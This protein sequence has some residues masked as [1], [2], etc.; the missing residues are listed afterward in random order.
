MTGNEHRPVLVLS[1]SQV[2]ELLDLDALIDGLAAAMA[3]LSGGRV[4][5]PPRIG[6]MVPE[7]DGILVAMPAYAP[8]VD[9]LTGKLLTDFAGNPA[10][11][12]P[13]G[14]SL[15]VA[16]DP[17]TG[18]PLALLHGDEIT[19][20]RTA[21]GSALS[22]RLLAREDASVLAVLGTGLQA[23]WHAR[24][25]PRVRGI[26]DIRVAGRDPQRAGALATE[27]ATELS[28]DARAADTYVEALDGA[29]IICATTPGG[30]PVVRRDWLAPG[31]HVTSIGLNPNG[32]EVDDDT[33]TQSLVCVESR[34]AALAAYPAGSND[35]T[36]PIRRGLIDP[37]HV[38]AEL[39]E[40]VLGTRPGRSTPSQLTLY[41]SVGLAL[42][43][44][45]ATALVLAAARER[46][47]GDPLA[48]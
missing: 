5:V 31:A 39:G 38:H 6:A 26:R 22:A 41:K 13:R 33:V 37:D 27:L 7:R 16:F 15:I 2:R 36:D 46:G 40:L 21:A 14:H 42:Q 11:G 32:R 29:D 34:S 4:A 20:A 19:A 17:H 1:R 9:A 25:L 45:T 30:E 3:D 10:R 24:A 35:L 44:A 18:A 23:R 43:D 28:L 8:G 48:I 47:I 12:L